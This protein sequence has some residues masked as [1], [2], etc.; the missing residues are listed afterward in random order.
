MGILGGVAKY[1]TSTGN[2]ENILKLWSWQTLYKSTWL[3]TSHG[4]IVQYV[5]YTS[6]KPWLK[7]MCKSEVTIWGGV[8][9]EDSAPEGEMPW[10]P[11]S[12]HCWCSF[13]SA[14]L[15]LTTASHCRPDCLWLGLQG[16]QHLRFQVVSID[17]RFVHPKDKMHQQLQIVPPV[18]WHWKRW[19]LGQNGIAGCSRSAGV[20]LHHVCLEVQGVG[21][22]CR[23]GDKGV[24]VRFLQNL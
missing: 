1:R 8:N 23:L 16:P 10:P 5:N 15:F 6:T 20:A 18:P 11:P 3:H 19:C 2:G 24:D 9:R 14:W 21:T 12:E 22:M 4:R 13:P 17:T 7:K